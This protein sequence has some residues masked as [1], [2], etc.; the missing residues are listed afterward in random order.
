VHRATAAQTI[1]HARTHRGKK[2]KEN[3]PRCGTTPGHKT[4]VTPESASKPRKAETVTN[5]R[6][7]T[8][9]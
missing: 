2:R 7:R 8:D 4:T 6:K 5:R 3:Q 1:E 9:D